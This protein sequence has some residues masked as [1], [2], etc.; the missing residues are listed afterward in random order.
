MQLEGNE[1]FILK[2]SKNWGVVGPKRPP[3]P[4]NPQNHQN[5]VPS[6]T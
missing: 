2:F 1:S 4:Q 5:I 3:G 6:S